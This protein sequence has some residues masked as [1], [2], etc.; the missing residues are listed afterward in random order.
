MNFIRCR[1]SI[2]FV[3]VRRR[4]G[5]DWRRLESYKLLIHRWMTYPCDVE[6]FVREGIAPLCIDESQI[7]DMT[8]AQ[9]V[10][11]ER[12]EDDLILMANLPISTSIGPAAVYFAVRRSTNTVE[13]VVVYPDTVEA[14]SQ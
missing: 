4:S 7:V 6:Y 10:P 2:A 9:Y 13:R 12:N 1:E 5:T 3:R 11:M 8:M 14:D